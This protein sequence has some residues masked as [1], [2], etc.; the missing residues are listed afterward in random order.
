MSFRWWWSSTALDPL[1]EGLTKTLACIM[2][3][4]ERLESKVDTMPTRA[5]LDAAE[6]ALKQAIADAATR[7][8]ADIKALRDALANGTP[9]TTADLDELQADVTALGQIDAPPTP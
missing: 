2:K 6:A 3:A 5:D 9:V 7:V 4:L 1:I 8:A